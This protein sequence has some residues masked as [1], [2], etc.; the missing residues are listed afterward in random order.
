MKRKSTNPGPRSAISKMVGLSLVLLVPA[1][2]AWAQAPQ[3]VKVDGSSTVNR[4]DGA[5]TS[6]GLLS[7]FSTG[8]IQATVTATRSTTGPTTNTITGYTITNA[9]AGYMTA[10]TVTVSGGGG[11]GAT[12]TAAISAEGR[13][14]SV[15]VVSPGSGY[16]STPTVALTAPAPG[17]VGSTV[18]FN[19]DI[20][21]NNLF[22]LNGNRTVGNMI[23]GDLSS[24]QTYT[25]ASGTN[26][27][28]IFDSEARAGAAYLN[29]FMGG[30][31]VISAPIV[32]NDQLNVRHTTA[33]LTLSGKISGGN[34]LT[35]YGNGVLAIT[36][37]NTG[38]GNAIPDYTLWLWN[39]GQGNANAQVELGATTGNAA[40]NIIVGNASLGTS[41]HAVL[42]LLQGRTNLDQIHDSATV[43]FDSYQ[44]SGRNNYFK[45]MGG[46]EAIGR[47]LD[48]GSLAVIENRESE[49]IGANTT[50]TGITGNSTTDVL[51]QSNHGFT[52]GQTVRF[53]SGT[54]FGGLNAST[55]YYVIRIDANTFK[56][57]TS[58]ANAMA[59]TPVPVDI[60]G[61]GT[62]GNFSS[63]HTLTVGGS[64]ASPVNTDSYVSGFIRDSSGSNLQQADADGSFGTRGLA[65]EKN[66]TGTLTLTGSNIIFTGGL[67]VNAGKVI[68]SQSTAPTTVAAMNF[69]SNIVNS[70]TVVFDTNSG[71]WLFQK[72]FADP[73]GTG[74]ERAPAT[75][76]LTVTGSGSVEKMGTGT[77]SLIGNQTIGGSLTVSNGTLNFQGSGASGSTVGSGLIVKGDSGLNRT[78]NLLG[79][80]SIT[81]GIDAIGRFNNTGSSISVKGTVFNAGDQE[82][83]FFE[84]GVATVNGAIKLNYMD[85]RLESNYSILA[86]ANKQAA[87]TS[88]NSTSLTVNN[89][90]SIV[91]GMR[92]FANGVEIGTINSINPVSRVIT[93]NQAAS[94]S[95]GA[96]LTFQYANSN[97]GVIT[98]SPSSLTLIGRPNAVGGALNAG[99]LYMVNSR[100]SNNTNRFP[101]ATPIISKGGIIEFSNDAT[102]NVF[103][104]TL[105]GVTLNQG[106]LQ[107]TGYQAG[108]GGTSTLT[109]TSLTRNAG[110]TVEFAGRDL[111]SGAAT[112]ATNSL[113]TNSRNR[114]LINGTVTLDDGIIGGW[115]YANNE[116]VK[117]G[118][119][120]VTRLLDTDYNI[121]VPAT[122]LST[123]N[124]KTGITANPAAIATR[125]AINSL[126]IQVDTGV[127]TNQP[128]RTVTINPNIILSIES[129][130]LL[131]SNGSHTI[132][133][134]ILTVGTAA[135]VPAELITTVG[136][137]SGSTNSSALTIISPIKD[138]SGPGVTAAASAGATKITLQVVTS[139]SNIAGARG[140][141]KGMVISHPNIP[142]GTTILDINY[143]T[144]EITLSNPISTAL[145]AGTQVTFTGGSVG[146]TKAGPGTLV[147]TNNQ[148]NTY[149]GPTIINNGI[150]RLR[151]QNNLGTAP[152]SFVANQLQLNGGTLQF[153]NDFI[154][155]NI[156]YPA[157]DI[158]FSISDDKRGVSVGEAGGR[159][160]VGHQ[161][162]NPGVNPAPDGTPNPTNP[163][164]K[165]N[166]TINNAIHADGLVELAVRNNSSAV[167][168]AVFNTLVL[169]DASKPNVGN[170][171]GGGIKTEGGFE[172]L[173]TI[174]GKNY[175]NGLFME[176]AQVTLPH[177]NNFSGP[178][179]LIGGTLNLNG[180]NTYNGTSNFSETISVAGASLVFGNNASLGIAGIKLSLGDGARIVLNGTNQKILSFNDINTSSA[181]SSTAVITNAGATPSVL[182]LDLSVN[183]IF[184][185]Q[186]DNG[187]SGS[188]SL[189]KTGPGRL[190]LSNSGSDFTGNVRIEGGGIDI[191]S[192]SF[193]GGESALGKGITGKASEIVINQA[194]L[195]FSPRGQ[196]FTNRSFTM[197]AGANGA[198][199]IANGINQA[200]RV[201]LGADFIF[202]EGTPFEERFVSEAVG[203]EGS[204]ART[205]TLSGVNTGD[206]EF[207]LQL[208]DKSASE[209]SSLLKIG[210]GTWALGTPGSF[211]GQTTVQEG[212]LA[213]LAN[214]VLGTSSIPTTV[215]TA[216]NTFTGNLPNGVELTF[217]RFTTSTLPGGTLP[218]TRYYVVNSTGTTFQISATRGGAS[219]DITS[220][221]LNVTYVP[222]IQA[223][224][225]TVSN[226]DNNTFTGNLP[227]GTPVVFNTQIPLRP[228][229]SGGAVAAVLPSGIN[230]YETYYVIE[231]NGTTFKVAKT[232]GGTVVDFG[233]STGSIFYTAYGI[234]NTSSGINVIGGR[235]ELRNVD[236]ITQETVNFQGGALSVPADTV[237]RWAGNFDIQA[238]ATFTVGAN[239]ELIL[240]GNILGNRPITQLGEGTIR[241]RGESITP[242]LPGSPTNELDNSRRS[243]TLQAG[244]LILDYGAN[245]NSKLVDTATLVLGGGRRG[246]TLR[247]QGGSHE[248]IV[249]ALSLQAGANRIFRDSGNGTIRLNTISRAE[250]SSL[251]FDLARIAT[252]DN[253]NVNNILGGWAVIRDALVHASWTLYG[254][255]SRNFTA[256]ADTDVMSVP[257]AQGIHHLINGAPVRL[258][259]TGTLPAP[260]ISGKTYYVTNAGTRTFKL[261]ETPTGAPVDLVDAGSGSAQN[262]QHTVQVFSATQ[263]QG[264]ATLVF[265][266][267]QDNYPGDKGNGIFQIQIER[268][269]TPGAITSQVSG[270]A[271]PTVGNPMIYKI[272]TT[273]TSN[274]ANAIVNFVSSDFNAL[275]YFTVTQSGNDATADAGSYNGVL[276][277]GA[278]DSGSQQLGWARNSTNSL[279]GLVQPTSTYVTNVW[280]RNANTNVTDD[281]SR[282]E[283]SITYTLR[284]AN[285]VATGIELRAG[286]DPSILHT[287]QTG[288]ILVSPTV[289]ANDSTIYGPGRLTTDNEGNLRNFIVHQYNEEGD[290]VIGVPMV[291][292]AAIVRSGRLT[293]SADNSHT[294]LISGLARTDDLEI[295][296][297][298]FGSSNL[299]V[300][301]AGIPLGATIAAILDRHTVMLSVAT[302]GG[303][304]RD[305]LTFVV[306]G[307]PIRR[308]GSQQGSGTQNR[309]LGVNKPDG[310]GGSILSTSDIY[311]GMPIS[312]PGIPAGTT[313]SSILN[314]S[315]I[316]VST[317][318]FFNGIVSTFTLTPSV[319]LE[320]LGGGTLVLSGNN[321]YSGITTLADGV[322]RATTLTD[323]GVAGSLGISNN[324]AANLNFN[325]GSLQY[326][327]ENSS[328]NRSFTITE[329]ARINIGHEKTTSVFTNTATITGTGTIG[330]T[331]RIEKIGSGTLEMRGGSN[332]NEIKVVE[333][334]LRIQTVDTNPT[335]GTFSPSNF[336]QTGVTAVRLSG[337]A[338][339]VRGAEEGNI[340]QTFGGSLYVDEGASEVR[341]VSVLGYDPNNLNAG[342]IGR[343]TVLN[344]MGGE[345]ASTI[346]RSSGGTVRFVESLEASTGVSN[347]FLN[348]VTTDRA[349]VLPWAVYQIVASNILAGVNDFATVALANAA[350]VSADSEGRYDPGDFFMNVDNL[351]TVE[352]GSTIDATE[353]GQVQVN[354]PTGI[355][356]VEGSDELGVAS[357]KE[358][359]L[360]KL[361]IGMSVFGPGMQSATRVVAVDLIARKVKLN[362]VAT[363]SSVD[364]SFI[365]RKD[366]T[367][368]GTLTGSREVNTM[369]YYSDDDS[370]VTI[371]AGNTLR[372]VSGAILVA[373]NTHGADKSIMGSGNIT[374]GGIAGEGTDLII[375][376]YNPDGLFSIGANVI[377]NVVVLPA[378]LGTI[379]AGKNIMNVATGAFE[380]LNKIHV[381]MEITGDGLP[382]GTFAVS[383]DQIRSQITMSKNATASYADKEYSFRSNT[384]FVQT[385]T[386]TTSLSGNNI[387]TGSTFVHGGVLRLDSVNAVP[388]GIAT[389]APLSS[390]SHIVVKD[391]VVGLGHGDFSRSL[392]AADNQ[393]EF[394]G[395]GGFA[396][397]GADRT[398]NLGGAG[399][400]LRFGNDGFVAD[401]SSLV[402]GAYD[403]THK[404]TLLNPIDLGSFSQ[405][406]RVDNGP[407]EIEGELA[408]ALYGAGKLIKFGL[409]SLRLSAQNKHTGGIEIADGR[410]VVANVPDALG[411]GSGIV[412]MGT[413]VTNTSKSAAIELSVEGG[414]VSKNL[415]V[416][417]VNARGQDWVPRGAADSAVANSGSHASM[418]VINGNPAIAYYDATNGDLKFV[419]AA[420][421]RG[422]TWLTPLT[423]ASRGDVGLYP[424]LAII[425]GNPAVSYYDATNGT[426]CYIRSTDASGVFWSASLIAD[427]APVNAIDVQSDGKVIIGGSFTEFDGVAKTRVARLSS[428][429][430]LDTTW[431]NAVVDG[432]VRAIEVQTDDKI[433]IA[434]TFTKV[435][436]ADRNNIAR[437][438]ADGSL[439]AYNPNANGGI[440]TLLLQAGDELLVGGAFTNI[441]GAGRARVARLTAAGTATTFNPNVG[442]NE[443]FALAVE[444]DGDVL[445]GG[446]FTLVAGSSRNRIARVDSAGVLQAF[447]PNANSD[448]RGIVVAPDGKIYVGGLF[449][450]LVGTG[451]N[452]AF[453]R[454]RLARLNADGT[455]DRDY[456]VEVNA[457]VRG[458]LKLSSDKILIRGIFTGV[459]DVSVNSL[460]CLNSDGS[461]DTAF[462][463]DPDYEVRA[464]AEQGVSP[465]NKLLVGGVFSNV[466]GNTQHWVGR[467]NANGTHDTSFIRKVD[468]RGQYT[469]MISVGGTPV[470]AY[471]DVAKQDLRYI[472][473]T[474]VNGA[475]GT[476]QQSIIL[477]ETGDVGRGISMKVANIGGDL[478][479][480]NTTTNTVT[481]AGIATNGTPAVAYYDATNGDLKY[482]LA[483][484]AAGT[485]WSAPVILQSTGDVG[486]HVSLE[487]VNGF[488]AVAY[489]NAAG[490]LQY[491]R[492]KNTAGLAHNLR[493]ADGTVRTI[494]TNTLVFS[495]NQLGTVD[496]A[497]P[498]IWGIG[499]N[500][501]AEGTPVTLDSGGVGQFPSLAVVNGQPTTLLGT[502]AVAYYDVTKGDLKYT[503][504]LDAE[505]TTW[506]T[507]VQT[508]T[509]Q[510]TGNVGRNAT[511]VMT[512]GIPAI[513]YQDV[514]A[515][516][517]KFI[518]FSDATGYSRVAFT[519]DTTWSGAIDLQGNTLFA[520]EAG[521]TATIT[522]NITGPAGFRLVSEGTLLINSSGNSFGTAV[523]ADQ[524]APVVIR[525]GN[526]HLGSS[527]ALGN[528]R[529]DMGD[530]LAT[531]T[532]VVQRA[533]NSF[534]LL[535]NGGR[536]DSNHNG[537]FGNAGG[538]G[539]FVEVGTTIDGR[540]YSESDA[541]TLILVKDE[542]NNPQWNGV[543]QIAFTASGQLDG[544]MNLVRAASMDAVQEFKY[545]TQ[546]QV[547][548]GTYAGK[549][550]FLA[551]LVT[552]L[553][554]SAVH[555]TQDALNAGIALRANVSGLTIANNL[556]IY[557]RGNSGPMTLG[558]VDS[559]T[560][561]TVNFTGAITQKNLLPD[562]DDADNLPDTQSLNLHS[563][564]AAGTGVTFSGI[565][566]EDSLTGAGKLK[567]VKTGSGVATL[568]GDS[569]T[570]TGGVDVNS[571]TLLVMNPHPEVITNSATGSGLVT[572][573]AGAVLG[574]TGR[575]GGSVNL[576]GTGN[577]V[578][579]RAVLRPGD[580]NST[581]QPVETLTING[582]VT[583]GP[584]AVVEFTLGASNFTKL[585]ANSVSVTP[586]GR[587]LVALAAGYTPAVGT[588]FDIMDLAT[589]S[590]L[591]FT[592]GNV[593]LSE[594]LK[595]PG[596]YSWDTSL[597]LS[598]G[599]IKIAGTTQG[600]A[601]A[602]IV[603]NPTNPTVNPG[604]GTTVTF[605]VTVTGTPDYIYQ[606][607]KSVAGGPF[608]N[609][610]TEIRS[611]SA[612][613]TLTL[614]GVFE[615]DEGSYRVVVT[616]GEGA[617]IAT[618]DA[619]SLVV[620][621][622]PVIVQHPVSQTVNPGGTAT[623]TV[624]VAGPMP[625]TFQ[626]KRGL[627]NIP[628][629]DPDYQVTYPTPTTSQLTI[630]NIEEADQNDNINVVVSNLAGSTAPSNPAALSVNDPVT[631]T[632]HPGSI[633]VSNGDPAVFNVVVAGTGPFTYQWQINNGGATPFENVSDT[634]GV[635]SRLTLPEVTEADNNRLVRVTVTNSIGSV[636][637]NQAQLLVVPGAP[638]ILEQP[639]SYTLA[640]GSTLILQVK[641]GGAQAGRVLQWKRNKAAVK[642]GANVV[643]GVT[644]N[645]SV[646]EQLD[647][648]AVISTL[649]VTNISTG[650]AGDYTC[651]AKNNSVT[652]P[653]ST[654]AGTGQVVVASDPHSELAV[655]E[656]ANAV[657]TVT[658]V[659]PKG[660]VIT[661]KWKKNGT[662]LPVND[663][664]I[665]G[666]STKTL[667]LVKVTTDDTAI[668]TCE[669][670][671]AG[672]AP[673]N[674]VDA[675][676]YYL[677][678]T[679]LAPE[680]V[681]PIT[682]AQAMV[683]AQFD[684]KIAL[685]PDPQRAAVTVTATGLPPGLKV[686]KKGSAD[687]AE[688]GWWIS[689][690]PTAAN[691]K[692]A[693]GIES[694]YRV[695]ITATNTAGKISTLTVGTAPAGDPK[696]DPALDVKKI[697][698][699]A[700]GVFAGWLPRHALNDGIGGR[701]DMTVIDRGSFTGKLT[702]GSAVHSFKGIL[703]LDATLATAP[704]A[705]VTVTRTGK[706]V[707]AP[708]TL[709]FTLNTSTNL[710]TNAS[711]TDGASA[712]LAFTGW[713]N[714][715]SKTLLPATV[716][717]NT[718]GT[719]DA[720]DDKPGYYTMAISPPDGSADLMPQGD[721]F[722]SFSVNPDG[723]LKL[724]GK[725]A[726]GQAITGSQF[727]GPTG[728]VLFFQTFYKTTPKGSI[729]GQFNLNKEDDGAF[730]D[731]RITSAPA[732]APTWT[733]PENLTASNRL[734]RNGFG[735][736]ALTVSGGA[737]LEPGLNQL[738]LNLPV[739]PTPN[740]ADLTF[741][742]DG[743]DIEFGN[744]SLPYKGD[745]SIP[746][747][748]SQDSIDVLA[749]NK[750]LVPASIP[751]T[752]LSV[753]AKTG[754]FSGSFTSKE[755][756]EVFG[757][758][759]PKEVKRPGTFQG[760]LINI[761]TPQQPQQ[762]GVGYFLL[763]KYPT[764]EEPTIQKTQILSNQ[765][766]LE[767]SGN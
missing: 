90:S 543:Y 681:Y 250:G 15:T 216:A 265:T 688:R 127:T 82:T 535:S 664:E 84:N 174:N 730:S 339:E 7:Y 752:K 429:G 686:V 425:N 264:A 659:G 238:N 628:A 568:S 707:P 514:T 375:H 185:G 277:G 281:F 539:A 584:N 314:D 481:V 209:P 132:T 208:S 509:V 156:V 496:P 318:H 107:V 741:S 330:A 652:K 749:G 708:L 354:F 321:S 329:F 384:S 247:L 73:D 370:T 546:V 287:L 31:D 373:T 80:T 135:N 700:V 240:D 382:A 101:D 710:L 284:F 590:S 4:T 85:L 291:D 569:N 253:L 545:G 670:T 458:M 229:G 629:N 406:V 65:L 92:V 337:G 230:A 625:Y 361:L 633:T 677:S 657:M 63:I 698:E 109:L 466:G 758:G 454:N 334:R 721:G 152:S 220:V 391:G 249:N 703:D 81:G 227:N 455:L 556:D 675:G 205:L 168:G 552:D 531:T 45:L 258:T 219:I 396:A 21:A 286:E 697:P 39:K 592:A 181:T 695:K 586:T 651:E 349:K 480:K 507:P 612:T 336:G 444:P 141:V 268:V 325:G 409:G 661:Y 757:S 97:D 469:S 18:H 512:D 644:S 272:I 217:P 201:V 550:Y 690:I 333:G 244:T 567:L 377:D 3:L 424:S 164:P 495:R 655:K 394:K 186:L 605:T 11:T 343:T 650:L 98:G 638:S 476:W 411:T 426:L 110:A 140:L 547:T 210:P 667:T 14:I 639:K 374:S 765:V 528:A 606:W 306:A 482:V 23:L 76:F 34:V 524:S 536:F 190:S 646:T 57:A 679:K 479:T 187:G 234:G 459:G 689:G 506:P 183:E 263:R 580:P 634:D 761:G 386:G 630:S 649:T 706:P 13:V 162:P 62:A 474:D 313:V 614:S 198:T 126:N 759:S 312:G 10:P 53:N 408:G 623:F 193:A 501:G 742:L 255:V 69:R 674:V 483:N 278:N 180:I 478:I 176:G 380:T 517:M 326:V 243:Y 452:T 413:S 751:A 232:V 665:K 194:A 565:I 457:E 182:T 578:G 178:I 575:I 669:V 218:N 521:Q 116:F 750:L 498:A 114:I 583:V 231:S 450:T 290:L 635:D 320:K 376:N 587:I 641:V 440:R 585:A 304:R 353:G 276:S 734:Y 146:L 692:D 199:L 28:L 609:K 419:R 50:Y 202:E 680:L 549:A 195:S 282:A 737:Y 61:N 493:N 728:Q 711:V 508:V 241:L 709:T 197:G 701:F 102:N 149:S 137:N 733:C 357:A 188:L 308:F 42:Q 192:I 350:I 510:S 647:G 518:H 640:A 358:P 662:D 401:G 40:G 428:T 228:Q 603:S 179:R 237:A 487:L 599:K 441:G 694:P 200:A 571:G 362:K 22:E 68:L 212:V 317:N 613:N 702:L 595:L 421:P 627:T 379:I 136:T 204:G 225:S 486:S 122:W 41:G 579:T 89:S 115:A 6:W 414:S 191:T 261:A 397:Y 390:S 388:G 254:T 519:G 577:S 274:S 699:G 615:A 184:R 46:N 301:A 279:D 472:R 617:F 129:G 663:P 589:A 226:A 319:G 206:N 696:L 365:F 544:T 435:N 645:I 133:G 618:S 492:S 564:I 475:S 71:T 740:N 251:Y 159:I 167:G 745:P 534:S 537:L 221:G 275:D 604:I 766:I 163:I 352:A 523:A 74:P 359:E 145:T 345:E 43:T 196:I 704:T 296:A 154:T 239:S 562:G 94:V 297:Q 422:K 100:F 648:T 504:A 725:T 332:L 64:L 559:M 443:V 456:G 572:V 175:I 315:D 303:D 658:A 44:G 529:V 19:N 532:I 551:S 33:R 491:L 38:A 744:P 608:E 189:I 177:N 513:G 631:F 515:G 526:L 637:S 143:A 673:D 117:Y 576:I 246:G 155:T 678:V 260:L 289:G 47:I 392:G 593:V 267:H 555:W 130:G 666:V 368:Y 52:T 437:L 280:S 271:Q 242:T 123:D 412:G 636:T 525:S 105:G 398:V 653:I 364:L 416:G 56:L 557:S 574:G 142:A 369:R 410:L 310:Q 172:G 668:Y 233:A 113:G 266:A 601:I 762:I 399:D 103:S 434:G 417:N 83:S 88:S 764:V 26:G 327:G 385:G 347:I 420:D 118:A 55:I 461:V 131:A 257:L 348:T 591:T 485:D 490:S 322:L 447:N 619:I 49:T 342:K 622:P 405:V 693:T 430:V 60:T 95:A 283:G 51:T 203:F 245:N 96:A 442:D 446:N 754:A 344:L 248:E 553:N 600:V 236:Y 393:I 753:T 449:S 124:V 594:Y 400:R 738:I 624:G 511:L 713:R 520:P 29:K 468:D 760:V 371:N 453:T 285:N 1:P 763:P 323:G 530:R 20:T 731:N 522:G 106:N 467:L 717:I 451:L 660:P 470:I 104:E 499:G 743:L 93:L 224:A 340:T 527:T 747:D 671:G 554:V 27:S 222:N 32:L 9:G 2:A 24:T 356:V 119:N 431:F 739:P 588:E 573:N 223:V 720:S 16:T 298:V 582:A 355:T 620:N 656:G 36:G 213:V 722:A 672:T 705:T 134:G 294:K 540:T 610:G 139:P 331:D 439:D 59:S 54:N 211:S 311:I 215:N 538:P 503:R 367:F 144:N 767:P 207:Q 351:G 691:K 77:L 735:P 404:V 214:N 726:D 5:A 262:L 642:L 170:Y 128:A 548:Q 161:N 112:T 756:D 570:F 75:Q 505:G 300:S 563:N 418:A 719:S 125:T 235:L 432:E 288:A 598:Q 324:A 67:T 477:D 305:E 252:V 173:I 643:G 433:I 120:G 427:A 166:L 729:V 683:G 165:V 302:T 153:G 171:Y 712:P 341:A 626:W 541:G 8:M 86:A 542:Y 714:K 403:A 687:D 147:L 723:S 500:G 423:L 581:A 736:I 502:P 108:S 87:S 66:G 35:S 558:A 309:I 684:H 516:N 111:S 438:N 448:V 682:F 273:S 724:S 463:A 389:S 307:N 17:G 346:A 607:Q 533:T 150:L 464:L 465:A 269:N 484:T 25:I 415:Q 716:Y 299:T 259:T 676:T 445:I 158:N 715:W 335:P 561:G 596:Q 632:N 407:A 148:E 363:A 169:G 378:G 748:D 746:S 293:G 37:N 72:T 99:G 121:G 471:Y 328:T 256:N 366:R 151:S 473:S 654:P 402:L 91:A 685:D 436:G 157:A 597:F 494:A 560:S 602:S 718:Q 360:S 160:E 727:V 489:Y 383:V 566:S 270:P 295:G 58:I 30:N 611:T 387:Y 381:G 372:L 316:Q 616:N 621:D 70:G 488:P 48:L 755:R 79:K 292:R 395:S 732:T 338:L 78:V 12:A 497:T 460:A 462:M 138:F